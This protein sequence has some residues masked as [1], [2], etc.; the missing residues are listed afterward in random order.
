M[1]LILRTDNNL[2]I[3]IMLDDATETIFTNLQTASDGHHGAVHQRRYK[4]RYF[5]VSGGAAVFLVE[6]ATALQRPILSK[7]S[8]AAAC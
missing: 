3:R 1:A 5:F 2:P 6:K 8:A 7:Y 4:R